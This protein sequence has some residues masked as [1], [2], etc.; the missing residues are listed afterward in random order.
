MNSNP[1]DLVGL[2]Q[3]DE[4]TASAWFHNN[5]MVPAT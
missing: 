2:F 3:L 4:A 5:L 1:I